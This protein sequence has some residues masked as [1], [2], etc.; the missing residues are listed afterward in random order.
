MTACLNCNVEIELAWPTQKRKFC[1]KSCAASYN[2][3][4]APKRKPE[5]K[6][7]ICDKPCKTSRTFCSSCRD[8]RLV[9]WSTVTLG[10]VRS[11]AKYQLSAQVR[12]HARQVM[13]Q[14]DVTTACRVCGYGVHVELSHIKA[15]S[16]FPNDALMTEVNHPSNLQ[17]L[18]RNH[19]WEHDHGLLPDSS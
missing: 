5:G 1:G 16:D 13:R 9:D 7:R 2:N 17:Y 4:R 3:K 6:C 19:H 14:L 18:C 15:I 8:P 12:D 11:R 10:M